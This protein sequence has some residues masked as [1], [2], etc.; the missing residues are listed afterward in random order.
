MLRLLFSGRCQCRLPGEAFQIVRGFY[1]AARGEE[2]LLCW[3]GS[4]QTE[5][6]FLL[7][8]EGYFGMKNFRIIPTFLILLSSCVSQERV[9]WIQGQRCRS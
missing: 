7:K 8:I 6:A 5:V 3:I 1:W 2:D 9:V 4:Q